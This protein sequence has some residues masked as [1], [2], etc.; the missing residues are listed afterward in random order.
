MVVVALGVVV[1]WGCGL[2]VVGECTVESV[3]VLPRRPPPIGSLV[4]VVVVAW[5]TVAVVG[6]MWSWWKVVEAE[7]Y[8][9]DACG[10]WYA[11]WSPAVSS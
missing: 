7:T 8:H 5:R 9:V 3:R 2:G 6:G 11:R 1:V 10:C 4:V